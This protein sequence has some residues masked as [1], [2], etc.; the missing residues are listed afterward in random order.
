MDAPYST[1]HARHRSGDLCLCDNAHCLTH[2]AALSWLQPSHKDVCQTL[3]VR[4]TV[5]PHWLSPRHFRLSQTWMAVP[6]SCSDGAVSFVKDRIVD[7]EIPG[8]LY[9]VQCFRAYIQSDRQH[10][11]STS[12]FH[13]RQIFNKLRSR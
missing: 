8:Y 7:G 12:R 9:V 2:A 13:L 5:R 6:L 1:V 11:D 4:A 3:S 10:A